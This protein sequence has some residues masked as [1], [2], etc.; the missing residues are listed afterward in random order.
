MK[1]EK[2]S[3]NQ[4]RCTLTREDL[5]MRQ[6]KMSELA[7]GTEKTQNLCR[8]MIRE[9]QDHFRPMVF[10]LERDP[11]QNFPSV[12]RQCG[13]AGTAAG[14]INIH[15]QPE[16]FGRRKCGQLERK[17]IFDPDQ[18]F[19]YKIF[20]SIGVVSFHFQNIPSGSKPDLE[21]N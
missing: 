17:R 2:L 7:Y 14:K 10:H 5:A 9:R 16:L 12:I 13:C 8:E 18:G 6:L 20:C 19:E 11:F 3:E 15:I 1:I 4:I 21:R